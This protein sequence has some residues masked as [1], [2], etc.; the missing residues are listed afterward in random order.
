ME[1]SFEKDLNHYFGVLDSY[2]TSFPIFS[3]HTLY[4][5]NIL[6]I[7]CKAVSEFVKVN[8]MDLLCDIVFLLLVLVLAQ[9]LDLFKILVQTP[10]LH[11]VC[12]HYFEDIRITSAFS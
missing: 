11:F 8:C 2:I 4:S 1:E 5:S 10:P 9:A 7:I 12:V 6:S 3:S